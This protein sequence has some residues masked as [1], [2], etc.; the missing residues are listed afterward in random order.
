MI[1]IV[2]DDDVDHA[3]E[4]PAERVHVGKSEGRGELE[5][6]VDPTRSGT[7]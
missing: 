7:T 1:A 4:R 5:L 3:D 2:V 6:T